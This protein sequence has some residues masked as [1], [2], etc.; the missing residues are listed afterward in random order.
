[1]KI[2]YN[3]EN[4]EKKREKMKAI[5]FDFDGTIADTLP[6]LTEAVNAALAQLGY[7]QHGT[8]KGFINHGARELMRRAM[9][10][11][12]REDEEKLDRAFAIYETCYRRVYLHT[13]TPYAGIDETIQKI[14]PAALVGVLSNKPDEM[15]QGLV[16]QLFPHGEVDAAEGYE[17][18]KP[19]KPDP[20]LAKKLAARLGVALSDCLLVG[21]SDVD[22]ATAKN[23]GMAF[24]GA[25]WGFAGT[26]ALYAAGADVVAPTPGDL[27]KEIEK[28]I[29]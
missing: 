11:G 15:T 10:E 9:P 29:K 25:G 22:V 26:K 16:R 21:D 17:E 28:F 23:A 4:A 2:C 27:W 3:R 1:M 24:V 19:G 6:V 7:P 14:H 12:E 20:Y 5:L 18:G 8:V 13:D